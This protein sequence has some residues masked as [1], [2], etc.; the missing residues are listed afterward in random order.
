MRSK[1]P[2]REY[3]KKDHSRG[4]DY[5]GVNCVFWCHDENG[6]VLLHKRSQK[7]RDERGVWDCGAGSMEFGETFDK[8][9]RREVLEEYGVEP[10]KIEYV[11]T[12]NVIRDHEG[13]LTHWVTNIHLV[14][15]DPDKA[16]IGDPEKMDE[17]GWFS[18]D[19]LP[20]PLHSQLEDCMKMLRGYLDRKF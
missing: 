17:I 16:S 2:N 14:Q 11:G 19:N 7:C 12:K 3:K 15:V 13:R 18:L 1:N 4:V 6:R 9:V 5:I 8:T 10:L 20:L